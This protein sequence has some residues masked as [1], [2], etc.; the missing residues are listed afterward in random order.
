MWGG[1]VTYWNLTSDKFVSIIGRKLRAARVDVSLQLS[2]VEVKKVENCAIYDR[3]RTKV[4]KVWNLHQK[5]NS[6]S[7]WTISIHL[8]YTRTV[9][10]SNFNGFS[11]VRI[12]SRFRGILNFSTQFSTRI[13][14]FWYRSWKEKR[15]NE[16]LAS[17][18]VVNIHRKFELWT[19]TRKAKP[20]R[21]REIREIRLLVAILIFFCSFS[22]HCKSKEK[23][24]QIFFFIIAKKCKKVLPWSSCSP[25][26]GGQMKC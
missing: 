24:S 22:S 3:Q 7:L 6:V 12:R 15:K 11:R 18:Q 13:L 17:V 9:G 1:K 8:A 14:K 20:S 19:P 25:A 2:D 4:V 26:V 16:A 10:C 5:K 23:F 21:H